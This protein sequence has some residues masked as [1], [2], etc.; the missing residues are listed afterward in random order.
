MEFREQRKSKRVA[1]YNTEKQEIK[2]VSNKERL[3]KIHE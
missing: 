1:E 2:K 3:I